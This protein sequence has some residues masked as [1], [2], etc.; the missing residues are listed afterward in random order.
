MKDK[1]SRELADSICE[2]LTFCCSPEHEENLRAEA[3]R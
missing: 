2:F 1:L 3:Q